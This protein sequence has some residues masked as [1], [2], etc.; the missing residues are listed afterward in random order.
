[1]L[2]DRPAREKEI[3]RA[4]TKAAIKE[5]DEIYA[6]QFRRHVSPLEQ[7]RRITD[8]CDMVL[9]QQMGLSSFTPRQDGK[10]PWDV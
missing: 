6:D 2:A 3:L 8:T 4:L 10:S 5:F 7:F 9:R 1:M